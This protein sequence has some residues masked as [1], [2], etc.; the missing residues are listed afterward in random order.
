MF[1]WTKAVSAAVMTLLVACSDASQTTAPDLRES[2]AGPSLI[3]SDAAHGNG[4]AHFYFLPPMVSP[5]KAIFRGWNPDVQSPF[6]PDLRPVV[7][8]CEL[9]KGVCGAI[10]ATYSTTA[11]H[12][13]QRVRV[14]GA[15]WGDNLDKLKHYHV[16]WYTRLSRLSYKKMYRIRV[17]VDDVLLGYADVDVVRSFYEFRKVDQR[18]YVPL[19]DDWILPI[20][21]RI[22]KGFVA[23]LEVTPG[24]GTL[25]VGDTQQYSARVLD[26]HGADI[27]GFT[28][29]WESSDP[30]VAPVNETGFANAALP[31]QTVISAKAAGLT[32]S[33]KLIVDAGTNNATLASGFYHSCGIATSGEA[34]CWGINMNL[35][36]GNPGPNNPVAAAVSGGHQ[37]IAI[38]NGFQHTCALKED[39]TAWCW[40]AGGNGALGNEDGLN[41]SLPV[42]VDGGNTHFTALTAGANHTCGLTEAGAAYCW[43]WNSFGQL[44]TND[45]VGERVWTPSPVAGGHV[46]QSIDAGAF[47]TCGITSAGAALCWGYNGNGELGIGSTTTTA[48]FGMTVPTPVSGGQVYKALSAAQSHTCALDAG[49]AAYCWGYNGFG[50]IGNGVVGGVEVTP[51]PVNGGLTFVDLSTTMGYHTCG[52][53]ISGAAYC[54]GYN[55]F[56]QLGTGDSNASA[57]PIV[58][59]GSDTWAILAAGLYHTCGMTTAGVTKCWGYNAF[60]QLGNGGIANSSLPAAIVGDI[61]FERP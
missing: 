21:F 54:W 4:K 42:V 49:G 60:G 3:I 16:N 52:R 25:G 10:V 7:E 41:T 56:G 44:G 15:S 45:P 18:E 38:A 31:G 55:S 35:Q 46:F 19:L 11:G 20:T 26:L 37:F 8:V 57:E 6:D 34:Y 59:S 28:F 58:V 32:G 14:I 53:V 24:D 36:L 50:S 23:K 27:P 51:R 13:G 2:D 33:A 12:A 47:H 40:G 5:P 17:L 43:G 39:G 1:R 22:E 29:A 30:T 9:E 61:V 48:P